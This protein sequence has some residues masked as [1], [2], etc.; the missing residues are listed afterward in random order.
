MDAIN[1]NRF[2]SQIPVQLQSKAQNGVQDKTET[3]TQEMTQGKDESCTNQEYLLTYLKV[4]QTAYPEV[5]LLVALLKVQHPVA[6]QL[7]GGRGKTSP[8]AW[9]VSVEQ[10]P[11]N[12]I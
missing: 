11:G 3:A 5:V 6:K 10:S 1:Q 4:A 9:N 8:N 2:A 12:V 7:E